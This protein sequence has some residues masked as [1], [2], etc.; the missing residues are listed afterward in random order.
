MIELIH[1]H[2]QNKLH[3]VFKEANWID[4]NI[5]ILLFPEGGSLVFVLVSPGE[6][7]VNSDVQ[8]RKT[9]GFQLLLSAAE[10]MQ[11]RTELVIAR[12]RKKTLD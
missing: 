5:S 9:T 6:S 10:S 11:L 4:R 8:S 7:C 2:I 3:E 1:L 12:G